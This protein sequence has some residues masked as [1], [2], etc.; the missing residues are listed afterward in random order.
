[1]APVK[2]SRPLLS[3]GRRLLALLA[4]CAL[5]LSMAAATVQADSFDERRVRTGARLLR[6]MLAADAALESRKAAD[7]QLHVLLY[8]TDPALAGEIEGLIAP[9]S[10]GAVRGMKLA[11]ERTARLPA[12]DAAAPAVIYLAS[13]PADAELDRLV[14]WSIERRVLLV[15]PFEGHVERG[16]LAGLSI[17]AKVQ[18]Y[19]NLATAKAAGVQFKPIFLKV[20]KVHP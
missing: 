8:A 4:A 1:M 5:T 19:V 3:A 14:R 10:K 20:A 18:P 15:S 17:E 11:V 7:G 2:P 12:G 16:A 9:A 6:G 13:L